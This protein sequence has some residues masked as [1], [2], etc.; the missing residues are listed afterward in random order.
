VGLEICSLSLVSTTEK[1]LERKSSGSGLESR[2]HGRRDSLHWPRDTLYQQKLALTSPTS[3]CHS[4]GIVR[5]RTKAIVLDSFDLNIRKAVKKVPGILWPLRFSAP[6]VRTAW[7]ESFLRASF[8]EEARCSSEEAARQVASRDSG[9]CITIA[10]RA[11]HRLLCSNSSPRKTLLSSLNHHSLRISFRM[12]WLLPTLKMFF[13]EKVSQTWR[14]W[15]LIWRPN[16]LRFQK[17]P[18]AGVSKNGTIDGTSVCVCVCVCARARACVCVRACARARVILWRRLCK[19]CHMSYHYIATAPFRELF[20]CPFYIE[21]SKTLN[22]CHRDHKPSS[23]VPRKRHLWWIRA[24]KKTCN[25]DDSLVECLQFCIG[26]IKQ[27]VTLC[28]YSYIREG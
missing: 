22:W 20:D 12:F 27:I 24:G 3:D 16:S 25:R 11:T 4:I 17:K 14:K 15:D 5:S 21:V 13:K 28:K 23:Y 8:A 1:L 10:H 18:Y 26:W 9:S 19:C 2:E 7:T 6:W